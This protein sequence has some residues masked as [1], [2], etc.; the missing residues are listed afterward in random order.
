MF[1]FVSGTVDCLNACVLYVSMFMSIHEYMCLC[2][3]ML[4]TK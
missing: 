4:V 2:A 1:F 3:C